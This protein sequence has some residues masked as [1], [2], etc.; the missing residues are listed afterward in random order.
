[1]NKKDKRTHG[2]E[3]IKNILCLM[4]GEEYQ[5][6]LSDEC[7]DEML[8]VLE[9]QTNEQLEEKQTNNF[10]IELKMFKYRYGIDTEDKL[11]RTYDEVASKFNTTY[12]EAK[13]ADVKE[14]KQLYLI[15]YKTI[16][17]GLKP[18]TLLNKGLKK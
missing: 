16:K 15:F 8:Q 3:L 10:S 4:N 2:K 14:M 9:I 7:L 12:L 18:K 5:D 11:I 17:N 1:M 13:Q 6:D